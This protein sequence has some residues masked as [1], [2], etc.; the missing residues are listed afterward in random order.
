MR[1]CVIS[2]RLNQENGK[3]YGTGFFRYSADKTLTKL[4]D[5]GSSNWS[6]V[7]GLIDDFVPLM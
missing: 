5:K 7:S 3:R 2:E 1:A 6:V 4:N